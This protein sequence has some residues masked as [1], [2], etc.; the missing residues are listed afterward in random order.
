MPLAKCYVKIVMQNY[1]FE[2]LNTFKIITILML[3]GL[4]MNIVILLIKY[5]AY[6][7]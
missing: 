1:T 2:F 5:I 3:D 4:I 6:Y 7:L